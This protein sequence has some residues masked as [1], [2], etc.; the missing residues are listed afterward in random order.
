MDT[1][2]GYYTHHFIGLRMYTL[3]TVSTSKRTDGLMPITIIHI[4]PRFPAF[5]CH[6]ALES[7]HRNA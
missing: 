6:I 1:K 4:Y 7:K 3:L 5:Q 2:C